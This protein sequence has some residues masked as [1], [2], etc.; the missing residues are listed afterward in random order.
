M[1]LAGQLAEGLLDLLLR[2][3]LCDAERLV[4]VLEL[5]P[6]GPYKLKDYQSQPACDR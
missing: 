1:E 5:H 3:R 2:R 6:S 4:V